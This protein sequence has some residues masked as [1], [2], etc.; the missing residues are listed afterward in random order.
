MWTG[1]FGSKCRRPLVGKGKGVNFYGGHWC[2]EGQ[3]GA[4]EV[5]PRAFGGGEQEGGAIGGGGS[6]GRLG[7]DVVSEGSSGGP[8]V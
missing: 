2:S 4:R 7:D 8:D 3:E 5:P 1:A 6:G